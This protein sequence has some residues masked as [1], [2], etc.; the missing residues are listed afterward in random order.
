M[1]KKPLEDN[2]IDFP[3]TIEHLKVEVSILRDAYFQLEKAIAAQVGMEKDLKRSELKYRKLFESSK[4]AM[5]TLAPPSWKFTSGNIEIIKMFN[6]KDE[7]E[8]TT[9]GPWDLSPAYQPDGQLSSVKA[10]KMIE[11]AMKTG[12]NYFEWVHKKLNG[13]SFF[14][15]VL[16]T[17]IKY[18]TEEYLQATVRDI[19][20]RKGAELAL[21][22]SE[23]KYRNLI[24]T[25]LDMIQSVSPDTKFQFVNDVWL[26]TLGYTRKDVENL[27]M[28]KIIHPDSLEH[29]K[30]IFSKVMSGEPAS[31][32]EAIFVAKDG[33]QVNVEGNATPVIIDGKVTATHGFFKDVTKSK[34]EEEARKRSEEK[35]RTLSDN[36]PG[37]IYRAKPDWS[38]EIVSNSDVVCGYSVE[39]L[40]SGEVNWLGLIHPD[41]KKRII[42]ESSKMTTK[43]LEV[44][45]EYRVIAKDK[46][47]RWVEDNKVSLFKDDVFLGVDG[48]VFNITE[49]KKAEN[50]LKERMKEL[51]LIYEISRIME[52]EGGDIDK[53]LNEAVEVIPSAYQF[54]ELV[55]ASISYGGKTHETKN[56]KKT[57]WRQSSIIKVS[58]KEVGML[59]IFYLKEISFLPEEDKMINEAAS[60]IGNT[61]ERKEVERELR[62]SRESLTTAQQIAH[63]GNWDWNIVTNELWWSEEIYR[64]FGLKPLEFKATYDAFLASIHPEDRDLV[65]KSVK[66]A[67]IKNNYNINHRIILPSGE[68]RFVHEEAKVAYDK[69]GKPIRMLGIVQDITDIRKA[70]TQATQLAIEKAKA[71]EAETVVEEMKKLDKMKDEFL[72]IASHELRTP[73]TAIR[74]NSS[75]ILEYFSDRLQDEQMKEVIGDIHKGSVRLTEIVN[76]FLDVSR[77]EGGRMKF[78]KQKLDLQKLVSEVVEEFSKIAS[79]KNL[80]LQFEEVPGRVPSAL[81]DETRTKQVLTNLIGNSIKYTHKGKIVVKAEKK[82]DCVKIQ[83]SD[84][85]VGISEEKQGLLFHKFQ[86]AGEDVLTRDVT[87]GSGLGLYISKMLVEGMGGKIYLEKS[88]LGKG[89]TFAF[90]LPID[91]SSA[92]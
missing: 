28:F 6:V 15:T 37:M 44:K 25:S 91:K 82:D 53:A 67:L 63:L 77:L 19:T 32:I 73:L 56:F 48:I 52:K 4:D 1:I 81:G 21:K 69:S 41:D 70:Q 24:N 34:K 78:E 57:A 92:S 61:A 36:I 5:M 11:K 8:F 75:L 86:Q 72:D 65:D 80:V 71:K 22:K 74:G 38:T 29:C 85:G 40:N 3:K 2:K 27:N 30:N 50:N 31:N 60:L 64:I 84:T 7:K 68:V 59:E 45:Q 88:S 14:A 26:E 46:S 49:R 47:T 51:E 66:E 42:E 87:R 10:K 79:Q 62:D 58:G 89:S 16:L 43:P 17:K 23:E 20:F 83:V 39:E 55:C 33:R 18:G 54:P 13:K 35:Y 12:S 76:D 9:L 90:E